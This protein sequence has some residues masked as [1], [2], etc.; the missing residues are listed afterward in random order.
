MKR[1]EEPYKGDMN[2][3]SP[4]ILMSI[5][6]VIGVTAFLAVRL[7]DESLVTMVTQ[8]DGIVETFS[9]AFYLIGC[10]ICIIYLGRKKAVHQF[11]L[12]FWCTFCFLCFGE[13]ISWFQRIFQYDTPAFVEGVNQQNEFNIHNLFFLHGGKWIDYIHSGKFDFKLLLSSQNLFRAGFFF[14]FLIIPLVLK[15]GSMQFIQ[16][17]WHFPVPN[18][19]FMIATWTTLCF[20]FIL[21]AFSSGPL[22]TSLAE[23]RE[24]FYAFFIMAYLFLTPEFSKDETDRQPRIRPH[25]PV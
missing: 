11:W 2:R 16:N 14:Y 15:T 12:V 9:A 20:S 17:K 4:K 3:V 10:F 5:M 13:E 1:M 18:N 23:T 6:T 21:S 22:K 7:L 8:E 24:F 25:R 19:G